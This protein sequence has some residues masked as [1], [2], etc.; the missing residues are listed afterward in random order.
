MATALFLAFGVVLLALGLY[1]VAWPARAADTYRKIGGR[2]QRFLPYWTKSAP[3]DLR[4]WGTLLLIF[5][6]LMFWA[7]TR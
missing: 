2:R 1:N 3:A 5:S 7:A 6:G 4:R